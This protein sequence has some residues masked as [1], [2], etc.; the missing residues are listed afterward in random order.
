MFKR[1]ITLVLALLLVMQTVAFADPW[2]YSFYEKLYDDGIDEANGKV[3]YVAGTNNVGYK[4]KFA[5]DMGLIDTYAP[6]NAVTKKELKNAMALVFGGDAFFNQYFGE[7]ELADVLTVDEAVIVF[8]DAAGYGPYLKS[9]TAG[10]AFAYRAEAQ[11]RG[12]F[13][14]VKYAEASKTFTA[15]MFYKMFY[16]ALHI[17][18]IAA[19]YS[20]VGVEY[21]NTEL[22]LMDTELDLVM[23]EGI[24][25]GNSYTTLLG[26]PGVGEGS[27]LIDNNIYSTRTLEGIDDFIGYSVHAYLDKD[28][29]LCSIAVDER[30]NDTKTLDDSVEIKK[31]EWSK[32][33]FPYWDENDRV[34][35]IEI[36]RYADVI[37]NHIALPGYQKEDLDI[38]NGYL[39]FIDNNNDKKYDVVFIEEWISFLPRYVDKTDNTIEDR[40]TNVYDFSNLIENQDYKGIFDH[41]G[42]AVADLS[43]LNVNSA[44]SV[45]VE[46]NTFN[47]TEALILKEET[48][49]G[50]LSRNSSA[51]AFPIK[52]GDYEFK[53]GKAYYGEKSANFDHK[54]GTRI[55]VYVDQFGKIIKSVD[56]Q[57]VEKFGWVMNIKKIDDL[58]D[59]G[60]KIH[61][62]TENDKF[63]TF[64][65]AKKVTYNLGE[66]LTPTQI[67]TG[68]A[69]ELYNHETG[70]TPNQLVMYTLNAKGEVCAIET[71][72][73]TSNNFNGAV[74]NSDRLQLNYAGE[75]ILQGNAVMSFGSKYQFDKPSVKLF[76]IPKKNPER[77]DYYRIDTGDIW[78]EVP[79]TMEFYNVSETYRPEAIVCDVGNGYSNWV[80]GESTSKFILTKGSNYYP[81]EDEVVDYIEYALNDWY[82]TKYI[83][84]DVCEN[85]WRDGVNTTNEV[86]DPKKPAP[87]T[88]AYGAR[89]GQIFSI[90]DIR[91]GDVIDFT[92]N[93]E[94]RIMAFMVNLALDHTIPYEDQFFEDNRGDGGNAS[95]TRG[96]PNIDEFN[97]R[98]KDV[99][100]F[101]K[102]IARDERYI[103]V[104]C[105]DREDFETEEEYKAYNRTILAQS[106]HKVT[107]YDVDNDTVEHRTGLDIQVGDYIFIEMADATTRNYIIYRNSQN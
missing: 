4:V 81:A 55:M 59:S 19:A 37:Y 67:V 33:T 75:L 21:Y 104:N 76:K 52:I 92:V 77:L 49:E 34:K 18:T 73:K 56:V 102:V 87:N 70:T 39:K 24:V 72:D 43:G 90:E 107:I 5:M 71:A 38:D 15:E 13:T 63:E 74:C 64:P 42:N 25:T 62:F 84:P 27:I 50:V 7:D 98:G 48:Y 30:I 9:Q 44:V 17:D 54:L 101:G 68:S 82:E 6:G 61:M 95:G 88:T 69:R 29:Y 40:N 96:K 57:G 106:N 86:A 11:R 46:Y 105:K 3:Y 85:M 65:F 99:N 91:R 32:T 53:L 66:L 20:N 35:K 26:D 51:K 97:L 31:D 22:T 28:N 16:D 103:V 83:D 58:F 60:V 47:V 2:S 10:D 45:L 80:G 78:H 23:F 100:M 93:Y 8:M 79:Y 41:E 94:N 36:D 12:L 1:I 89:Y 14:S